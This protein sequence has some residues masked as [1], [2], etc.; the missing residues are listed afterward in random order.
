MEREEEGASMHIRSYSG[1]STGLANDSAQN[2]NNT[3]STTNLLLDLPFELAL[4]IFDFAG[5]PDVKS[6]LAIFKRLRLVSKEVSQLV[7]DCMISQYLKCVESKMEELNAKI[8]EQWS[9]HVSESKGQ[10]LTSIF[11]ELANVAEE[12]KFLKGK[13]EEKKE[14]RKTIFKIEDISMATKMQLLKVNL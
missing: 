11:S 7:N 3:A 1:K 13:V 14:A 12:L 2:N 5:G 8:A 9:G 6:K 10:K 4:C